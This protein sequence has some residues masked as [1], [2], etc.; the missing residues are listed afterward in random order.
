[1]QRRSFTGL[2]GATA[3]SLLATPAIAQPRPRGKVLVILSSATALELRDGKSYPTGFFLNELAAP[4]KALM[5]AGWEPVFANP[6][7]NAARW[8]PRSA[9]P[10]YYGGSQA[11]LDEAM[12]FVEDLAGLKA[13]RTL[14]AIAAEGVG[15]YAAVLIPGGH[16]ALQD[17]PTDPD[18][19]RVLRAC[20][21]AGKLTAAICHGPAAFLSTLPDPVAFVDAMT[22][23]DANA[24]QKLGQGWIYAG[25]LMT[26]FTT[27]EERL[28][29]ER[30]LQGRVRYYPTE[31]LAQAGA[32][33]VTGPDRKSLALQDRNLVTGQQPFSDDEF[34]RVFMAAL[35]KVA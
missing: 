29:E 28:A 16:A 9:A 33:V 32:R 25:Y 30:L 18:T 1:M 35:A 31:A 15:G 8:D 13:P 20:Q 12:R 23:G 4:A 21:A 14:A 2:L 6:K 27:S 5:D 24:A 7:G 11:K 17:L 19:G 10:I 26:A 34:T 3:A 22:R